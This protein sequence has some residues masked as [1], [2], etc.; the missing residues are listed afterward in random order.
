M[1]QDEPKGPKVVSNGSSTSKSYPRKGEKNLNLHQDCQ[2][3]Q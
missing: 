3:S 2:G 1:G